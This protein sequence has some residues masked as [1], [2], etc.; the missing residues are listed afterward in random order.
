[1]G[2][3]TRAVTYIASAALACSVPLVNKVEGVVYRPYIDI[4]GVPTVCAGVTGKDV[5]MGKTYTQA[6]CDALLAKH[7]K[8]ASDAVDQYVK[9]DIPVTTRASLISFTYN[10]GIG[11]FRKS[12]VLRMVNQGNIRAGCDHLYDWV[13]IT[14]VK[15]GNRIKVKVKGLQNRR[16][17]EHEYC[18]RDLN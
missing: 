5:I 15:N 2:I 8:Y 17:F 6:E 4:A 14:Q 9:V 1:M 12:T 3:K 13:Y 16:D 7:I 11:A 10:V 18:V